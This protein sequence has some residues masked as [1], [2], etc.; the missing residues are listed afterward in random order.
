MTRGDYLEYVC[1]YNREFIWGGGGGGGGGGG[2]NG[3][4]YMCLFEKNFTLE[5]KSIVVLTTVS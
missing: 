4:D 5:L 2:I 3:Q 1:M